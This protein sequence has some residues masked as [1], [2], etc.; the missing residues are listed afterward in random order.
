MADPN[1]S[2]RK[3]TCTLTVTTY[4]WLKL[5]INNPLLLSN[6]VVVSLF[7]VCNFFLS[8][9]PGEAQKSPIYYSCMTTLYLHSDISV[10]SFLTS[11]LMH[12]QQALLVACSSWKFQLVQDCA[13]SPC[14]HNIYY[15]YLYRKLI[16]RTISANRITVTAVLTSLFFSP[17][18][19]FVPCFSF[20]PFCLVLPV[21]QQREGE[22]LR[23]KVLPVTASWALPLLK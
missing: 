13:V 9:R 5:Q 6:G 12:I 21:G 20:T 17:L 23:L 8:Q 1:I 14:S 2:G 22:V 11:P 15:L 7:Q 16:F 10:W 19:V 18:L 3:T 4:L